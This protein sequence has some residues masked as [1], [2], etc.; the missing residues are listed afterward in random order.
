MQALS[1]SHQDD[2]PS[3]SVFDFVQ[4]LRVKRSLYGPL[5]DVFELCADRVRHLWFQRMGGSLAKSVNM[6]RHAAKKPAPP[7]PGIFSPLP[8]CD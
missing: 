3:D 1:V 7:A 8:I 6:I 5:R 2:E 4:G